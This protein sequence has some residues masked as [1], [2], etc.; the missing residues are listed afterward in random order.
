MEMSPSPSTAKAHRLC[1]E[2]SGCLPSLDS[3]TVPMHPDHSPR[4]RH[5]AP[6]GKKPNPERS[7]LWGTRGSRAG[8]HYGSPHTDSLCVP[9]PSESANRTLRDQRMS[10][11]AQERGHQL[12]VTSSHVACGDR[13][14]EARASPSTAGSKGQMRD[15]HGSQDTWFLKGGEKTWRHNGEVTAPKFPPEDRKV[16]SSAGHLNTNNLPQTRLKAPVAF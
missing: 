5:L 4:G 1:S 15:E 9:A 10:I 16:R 11:R 2:P 8:L 14:P 3:F 13:D 6:P 12:N 7:F